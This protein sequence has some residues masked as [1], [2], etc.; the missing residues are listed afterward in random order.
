MSELSDR[1]FEMGDGER[2][3]LTDATIRDVWSR[4]YNT[5][6]KPDWSNIYPYYLP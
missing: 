4:T 5:D 6:G 1:T 2:L 3:P